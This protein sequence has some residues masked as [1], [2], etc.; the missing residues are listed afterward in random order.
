MK[1]LAAMASKTSKY[2]SLAHIYVKQKTTN[3]IQIKSA[4]L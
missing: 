3:K 4:S 1:A 2:N